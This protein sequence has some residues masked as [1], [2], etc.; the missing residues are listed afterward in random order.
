VKLCHSN[1]SGPVISRA[2]LWEEDNH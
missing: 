2:Y 1:R